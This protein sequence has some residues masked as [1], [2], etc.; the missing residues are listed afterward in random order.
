MKNTVQKYC[1]FTNLPNIFIKKSQKVP[2]FI[3]FAYRTCQNA[4]KTNFFVSN[5]CPSEKIAV[6][7]QRIF[8]KVFLN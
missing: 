2:I 8:K 6:T 3:F 1:F 5:I 7:L 4:G